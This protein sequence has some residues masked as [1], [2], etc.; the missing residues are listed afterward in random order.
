M[1]CI[2]QDPAVAAQCL[3]QRVQCRLARENRANPLIPGEPSNAAL[4]SRPRSP[5][6]LI[7]CHLVC[8]PVT[9]DDE[10]AGPVHLYHAKRSAPPV[11]A[12]TLSHD[13]RWPSANLRSLRRPRR[14][15]A[16]ELIDCAWRA[17]ARCRISL[18]YRPLGFPS[19]PH[20]RAAV[21]C[22]RRLAA[23]L[24]L[25]CCGRTRYRTI[26]RG[27]CRDQA[28]GTRDTRKQNACGL[29]RAH[30]RR[31]PASTPSTGDRRFTRRRR[32]LRLSGLGACRENGG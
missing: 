15:Q 25:R 6:G 32:R 19:A 31:L 21:L 11:C 12:A 7:L 2:L 22:C 30:V 23:L 27:C 29:G 18:R 17:A 1:A 13:A 9:W 16:A 28:R 3:L 8:V 5:S 10:H 26:E 20:K 4:G 14:S 24:W